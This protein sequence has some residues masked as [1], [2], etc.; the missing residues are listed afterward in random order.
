MIQP[1]NF[2]KYNLYNKSP[3]DGCLDFFLSLGIT[4][5]GPHCTRSCV[6]M[7][8]WMEGNFIEWMAVLTLIDPASFPFK[9]FCQFMLQ[10][11]VDEN[12]GRILERRKNEKMGPS[13]LPSLC[14]QEGTE[15][16]TF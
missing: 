12:I 3:M 7:R 1:N 15:L 10:P 4:N 16:T 8:V 9:W 14:I 5:S 13:C 6:H 11:A 2:G